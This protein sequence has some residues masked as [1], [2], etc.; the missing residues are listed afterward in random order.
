MELNKLKRIKEL[1]S[2]AMYFDEETG[3]ILEVR[4]PENIWV[5]VAKIKEVHSVIR[6]L[7]TADQKY[8]RRKKHE[9]RS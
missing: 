4:K 8:Y 9:R 5:V 3:E 2:Y 1:K 7:I 6:G